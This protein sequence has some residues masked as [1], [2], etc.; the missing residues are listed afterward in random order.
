VG[1]PESS[2][3]LPTL[4][5]PIPLMSPSPQSRRFCF[6]INN[7]S[8]A[9]AEAV[10]GLASKAVYLIA[11]DEV[12]EQGTPHIQGYVVF[13]KNYRLSKLSKLL[14]RAYIT[15]ARGTSEE[16]QK[17]CK[18]GEKYEE[19]GDCP[20]DERFSK[21]KNDDIWAEALALARQGKVSDIRP[22]LQIRYL[23]NFERIAAKSVSKAVIND[24]LYNL[25]IY[26][27]TGT[28]KTRWCHDVF[29]GHYQKLKNKWWCDYQNQPV[30]IMQEFG[31]KHAMLSEHVKEWADHYPF[32]CENKG[33]G[34]VIN[35][36]MLIITSNYSPDQ[37]WEEEEILDPIN[38]RFIV[39]KF[40]DEKPSEE[41]IQEWKE[42]IAGSLDQHQTCSNC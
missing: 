27:T 7:P 21:S 37:I 19:Y 29:P 17:Y 34:S 16:N 36:K 12:G 38:R 23:R 42:F 35:C 33:G 1:C 24:R 28:G 11:G 10:Y 25:W 2:L 20:K 6:T 40:P 31:K 4:G 15:V 32:R 26:G 39:L 8:V 9:D 22:D 30:V 5:C 41:K 14:S 18:K 3:L 13:D